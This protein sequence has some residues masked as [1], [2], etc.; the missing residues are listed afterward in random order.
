MLIISLEISGIIVDV[1]LDTG[2]PTLISNKTL[3]KINN[4][5][6]KKCDY[7]GPAI[8]SGCGTKMV[9]SGWVH[10][11]FNI[12]EKVINDFPVRL[13]DDL[14]FD[15]VVGADLIKVSRIHESK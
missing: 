6:L 4:E 9:P 8:I 10:L 7:K 14:P 13:I 1:V 2:A 5:N 11:N 15:F 12:V 3:S